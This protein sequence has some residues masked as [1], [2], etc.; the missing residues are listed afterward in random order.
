[1]DGPPLPVYCANCDTI[2]PSNNYL[3]AGSYFNSW[4]NE[5]PC[6]ECGN[7]HAKVSEGVFDL[8]GEYIKVISAPEFTHDL[9]RAI[10]G[11]AQDY[12]DHNLTPDEAVSRFEAVSPKFGDLAKKAFKMGMAALTFIA[13]LATIDTYRLTRE[14]ASLAREQTA[15][16]REGLKIQKE[17][18]QPLTQEQLLEI[19][20]TMRFVS[21]DAKPTTADPHTM[22]HAEEPTIKKSAPHSK[23]AKTASKRKQKAREVRRKAAHERRCMFQPERRLPPPKNG[24]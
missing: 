12:L 24:K 14:Q 21:L 13:L 16:A 5:E 11:I 19:I 8:S 23:V 4:D 15:I 9:I 22:A 10:G 18:P 17:A 2:F 3:Y 6:P 7:E 1:M 20:K